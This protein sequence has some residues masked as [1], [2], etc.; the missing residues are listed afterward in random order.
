MLQIERRYTS[1][2]RSRRGLTALTSFGLQALAV[3]VLLIL[4]LLRPQES[5]FFR[6]LSTTVS[7]GTTLGELLAPRTRAGGNP[8]AAPALAAVNAEAEDLVVADCLREQRRRAGTPE[9]HTVGHRRMRVR[10]DSSATREHR[11]S[12][13]VLRSYPTMPGYLPISAVSSWSE[14]QRT[15]AMSSNRT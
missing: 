11:N 1:N 6:H 13:N 9:H 14:R 7:L 12:T 8:A 2:A 5:P 4:P 10:T 15:I 3:A